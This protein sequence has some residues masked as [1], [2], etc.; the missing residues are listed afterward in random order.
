MFK[1]NRKISK[2]LPVILITGFSFFTQA[3][4]IKDLTSQ[5]TSDKVESE[6]DKIVAIANNK[7]PHAI[8][9]GL[10]QTF[11]LGDFADNGD[12]KITPDL[13]YNYIASHS[14][15]FLANFHW[16]SHKHG[17]TKTTLSGLALG[18][19]AKLYNFDNFSPFGTAGLGFYNPKMKREINGVYKQ[20]E[21]HLSFG[22]H[23][24]AGADLDLN[25]RVRVG[26]IGMVFNPFD[27][28]QDN[29]PDVEGAYYK[30]QLTAFYK[31]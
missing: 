22:Y 28:K 1:T 3:K 26:L 21:T 2:I 6:V 14:F 18:I 23:F 11:L 25:D 17:R 16:S 31:F 7:N 5:N 29:Q 13:Y 20:S 27:I 15:D 4:S 12:D 8:G 30:L 19:K 9:I 24:G 10:G